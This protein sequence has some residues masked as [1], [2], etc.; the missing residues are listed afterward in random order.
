MQVYMNTIYVLYKYKNI[1]IHY[2]HNIQQD[3]KD[4]MLLLQLLLLQQQLLLV[5]LLLLE[6]LVHREPVVYEMIQIIKPKP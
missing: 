6:T 2:K 3:I 1:I 4:I 5:L